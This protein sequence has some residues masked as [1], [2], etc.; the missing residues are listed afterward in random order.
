MRENDPFASR[1]ERRKSRAERKSPLILGAVDNPYRYRSYD[2]I[3][4]GEKMK[5]YSTTENYYDKTITI[6]S[7]SYK[8]KYEVKGQVEIKQ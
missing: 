7:K 5:Y 2:T 8:Y 3:L 1:E 4:N 6:P